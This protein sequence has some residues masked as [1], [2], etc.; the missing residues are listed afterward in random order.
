LSP[1][2]AIREIRALVDGKETVAFTAHARKRMKERHVSDMDVIRCLRGG[3]IEEGPYRDLK[4][5]Q[6]RCNVEGRWA[7]DTIRVGVA[8]PGGAIIVITVIDVES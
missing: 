5:G 1:A 6:W 4:T 7:G 8:L 2:E 3:S